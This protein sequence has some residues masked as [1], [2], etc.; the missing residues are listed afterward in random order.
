MKSMILL[1]SIVSI[2]FFAP[3]FTKASDFGVSLSATVVGP[4]TINDF[5]FSGINP[6]GIP[7][8]DTGSVKGASTVAGKDYTAQIIA[9]ELGAVLLALM[10]YRF[11]KLLR[12]RRQKLIKLPLNTI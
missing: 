3:S 6:N 8:G 5:D 1:L 10:F 2:L 11:M 12:K 7:I 4:P 9:F